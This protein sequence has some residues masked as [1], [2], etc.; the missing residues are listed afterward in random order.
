M[1]FYGLGINGKMSELQ[2]AMGLA[3]LPYMETILAERKRVVDYY[4]QHL[5]FLKLRT[6]KIREKTIW[7]YSYYP[8]VFQNEEQLLRIQQHLNEDQIF[9]R[10]YFYPSL[11]TINYSKGQM[12][13]I[14]ESIASRIMCLP[15]YVGLFEVDLEKIV[16]LIKKNI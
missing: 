9:P 8:L 6:I 10:R 16:Q 1:A 2:A 3:V 15:L 11:N 13:P 4:N 5:D 7:N 12:M 14:S